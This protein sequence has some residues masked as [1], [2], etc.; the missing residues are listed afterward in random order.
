MA[1][2]TYSVYNAE[3]QPTIAHDLDCVAPVSA[4]TGF[5]A[6]RNLLKPLNHLHDLRTKEQV[7][8][9]VRLHNIVTPAEP[10]AANYELL[11]RHQ[12]GHVETDV[13][14]DEIADQC[15]MSGVELRKLLTAY[16]EVPH[17]EFHPS[18]VCN[19]CCT[20]CTYFH[21]DPRRKPPAIHYP[22]P[23]VR[24]VAKL[25]PRSMVIIGGGEP[26]L[27]R[28]GDSF[29]PEL[30]AEIRAYMP[31]IRL[32]LV[33]NG[34]HKPAGSWPNC[35]DWIRV[36]LD[37]ATG[38]TYESFRGK[39]LFRRVTEHYLS[40]LEHDVPRVGISFLFARSNV[41]EYAD[42]AR[43][44][45]DL[46]RTR[47]PEALHKVNIQYRPL[48]R[49]PVRYDQPFTEAVTEP[50]IERAINEIK[51]LAA[52]SEQMRRF[53]RDQTNATAI[54]GGNTHPPHEFG[55]CY[56]SQVFRIVR[57]NGDLRPCFI[58]VLEPEFLL[59]NILRDPPEKIALN[60]L[61]VAALN[62][63]HCDR[64]GCRQCH[65]NYVLEQGLSG[66]RR[67]STSLVVRSDP[68]F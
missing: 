49:D 35:F 29:F 7:A 56:Y 51:E 38:S 16:V 14:V 48:R 58:R 30:V 52:T 28:S 55:R 31:G 65:V 5:H 61:Y 4:D 13:A 68:M 26:T 3:A 59:G 46:V 23:D 62:K 66:A 54:L 25:R 50:Q 53:L 40:Y 41:H 67:P 17:I 6:A 60:A 64:H 57:A 34:T 8:V 33:T 39:D 2:A 27:Y 24:H 45:F 10:F 19:L 9:D 36:S 42:V 12:A 18:D 43:F 21:D 32:A 37:A 63:P 20:G 11:R 44:I 22:L 15:G 47:R 1:D